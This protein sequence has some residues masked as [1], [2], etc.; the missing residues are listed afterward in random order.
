[1]SE[2]TVLLTR[3]DGSTLNTEYCNIFEL[4]GDKVKRQIAFTGVV[5]NPP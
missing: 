2:G 1:M 3:K 4:E 5:P